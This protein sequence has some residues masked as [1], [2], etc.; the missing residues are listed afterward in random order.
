MN[1]IQKS[2]CSV[3]VILLI[4]CSVSND[5][6]LNA[7]TELKKFNHSAA[8]AKYQKVN[9]INKEN[10]YGDWTMISSFFTIKSIQ[11]V[12]TFQLEGRKY[13]IN[14][15][16]SLII[17]NKALGVQK[18]NRLLNRKWLLESNNTIFNNGTESWHV[19]VKGD[20]ME[21]IEQIDENYSYFVL[22]K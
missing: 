17:D 1:K 9:P 4:S 14:E 16:G 19:R 13:T 6:P 8:E 2:L 21:W 11:S 20:T 7:I 22:V 15:D 12:T 3:S 18:K 5:E 10:L